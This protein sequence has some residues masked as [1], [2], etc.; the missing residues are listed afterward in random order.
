MFNGKDYRRMA[1]VA[2]RIGSKEHRYRRPRRPCTQSSMPY[3][4]GK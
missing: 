2:E 1:L 3:F 4:A